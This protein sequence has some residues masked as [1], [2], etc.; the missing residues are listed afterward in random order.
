VG[1]QL[2]G[3]L[4]ARLAA[5]GCLILRIETSSLEGEGGAARFYQRAG[6]AEVGR[7]EDFYREG[8]HL[9]TFAKRLS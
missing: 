6:F 3:E 9:I 4:E 7:I 1:R 8:D 5:R 2:L